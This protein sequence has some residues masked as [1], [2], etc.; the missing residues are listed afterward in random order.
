MARSLPQS[1]RV[2]SL[3]SD[4]LFPSLQRRGYAV[5]VLHVCSGGGSRVGKLED[6]SATATKQAS[7]EAASA[8][9][10][11]PV[12]GYYRP[13]NHSPEI[14]PAELRLM[15]LNHKVRSPTHST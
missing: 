8:W 13:M 3:V 11:D 5:S 4:V 9:V 2:L 15:L 1:K 6:T 10:P 14:D 7:S 12:T